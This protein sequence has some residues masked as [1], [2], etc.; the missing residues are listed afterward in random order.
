MHFDPLLGVFFHWLGEWRSEA[1]RERRL[2]S[3]TQSVHHDRAH[4]VEPLVRE[5]ELA[6][7]LE[8]PGKQAIVWANDFVQV[9]DL[10]HVTRLALAG[11]DIRGDVFQWSKQRE[12]PK[13]FVLTTER[14]SWILEGSDVASIGHVLESL[15]REPC[16]AGLTEHAPFVYG[17][18]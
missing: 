11:H 1:R 3:T 2:A 12:E 8:F 4:A 5:H 17:R 7:S 16:M 14:G 13:R 18:I 15:F 10:R 6:L 9:E